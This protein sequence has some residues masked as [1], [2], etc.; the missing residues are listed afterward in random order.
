M[1]SYYSAAEMRC[2]RS[3]LQPC[4]TRYTVQNLTRLYNRAGRMGQKLYNAAR[5]HVSEQLVASLL[6][7]NLAY[8][9]MPYA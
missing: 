6:T 8:Q 7:H 4:A 1:T 2:S 3:H 9:T 5:A